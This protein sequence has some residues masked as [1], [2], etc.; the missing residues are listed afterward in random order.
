MRDSSGWLRNFA[1]TITSLPLA[2]ADAK[3]TVAKTS[4]KPRASH[5]VTASIGIEVDSEIEL[6]EGDEDDFKQGQLTDEDA[7]GFESN[8]EL[9]DSLASDPVKLKDTLSLEVSCLPDSEY[10]AVAY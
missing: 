5:K 6:S 7:G 2:L 9:L 3:S 10:R 4:I 8:D 1:R